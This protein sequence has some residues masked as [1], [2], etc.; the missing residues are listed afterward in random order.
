MPSEPQPVMKYFE[1]CI[2]TKAIAGQGVRAKQSVLPLATNTETSKCE[3]AGTGR[4]YASC[5]CHSAFVCKS[6]TT[7]PVPGAATH[8]TRSL[9]VEI[10]DYRHQPRISQFFCV[11]FLNICY[12]YKQAMSD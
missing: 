7:R 10:V 3:L 9:T 11:P 2:P 1:R 8:E 5:C 12:I 6:R 4:A